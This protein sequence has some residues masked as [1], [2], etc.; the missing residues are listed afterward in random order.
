MMDEKTLTAVSTSLVLFQIQINALLLLVDRQ[1][2]NGTIREDFQ[3]SVTE[4]VQAVGMETMEGIKNRICEGS[5]SR[6]S[7]RWAWMTTPESC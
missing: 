5:F 7:K 3:R 4:G 1:T 2:G 6:I